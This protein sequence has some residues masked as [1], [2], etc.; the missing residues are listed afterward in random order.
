M[1]D[2]H[3]VIRTAL[4][5]LSAVSSG[6]APDPGD[7]AALRAHNPELALLPLDELACEVVQKA[8]R[9]APQPPARAAEA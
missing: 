3:N 4:R 6:H 1:P 8:L 9:S 5:I 2:H 7:A